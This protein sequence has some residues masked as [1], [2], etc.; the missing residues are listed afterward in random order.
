MST[1]APVF[2]RLRRV[3][4]VFCV[5]CHSL[6]S[7]HF[8]V[9][10]DMT[11]AGRHNARTPS[12]DSPNAMAKTALTSTQALSVYSREENIGEELLSR[13]FMGRYRSDGYVWHVAVKVK[14]LDICRFQSRLGVCVA[15]AR[16]PRAVRVITCGN[17]IATRL[18]LSC[19]RC[20]V[21]ILTAI[22]QILVS[23]AAKR[24]LMCKRT[25]LPGLLFPRV[26]PRPWEPDCYT[27]FLSSP[28]VG[29]EYM[30][31]VTWQAQHL[32]LHYD[33]CTQRVSRTYPVVGF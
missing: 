29:P 8:S 32:T 6:L 9:P 19:T 4:A 1:A 7:P 16:A 31:T 22:A 14:L 25:I 2:P 30:A 12:Y 20:H 21:G 3:D 33:T 24:A 5:I 15:A 11:C 17:M 28:V 23:P 13:V 18:G 27:V 10:P 26:P